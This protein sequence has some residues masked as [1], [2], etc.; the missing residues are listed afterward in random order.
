M[1]KHMDETQAYFNAVASQWDAMRRQFFGDGVRRAA[2]E[3]A[4]I[5]PG[6]LVIDVGTGTGSADTLTGDNGED[7][8]LSY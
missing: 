8:S 6:A 4:G 5:T 3:A 7:T 2:I 1:E